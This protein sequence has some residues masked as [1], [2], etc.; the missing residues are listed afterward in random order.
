MASKPR[1]LQL[2]IIIVNYNVRDFLHHALISLRKATKGI[3]SE[4]I[5]VDN[6]SDDGSTE[7]LRKR[8]PNVT[9]IASKQNLGFARANN[10]ALKRARGAFLLLINPDTVVQ[11]DTLRAMLEFFKN[12]P[13]AGLAGC[14]ILNPDGTF[15][16]ACR[17]SF[18]TPWVAFTKI[19]GLSKLFPRSSWFGKYNLTYLSP[20]ETYEVDA[21][22]GSFMMLLKEVFE[23]VG[24]LDEEFFMYGEDLDW[25]YRIQQSGWKIYYAP[26][27]QIIHYKGESTRRSSLDEIQTFYDAMHRFVKKHFGRSSFLRIV[28]RAGIM[29]TLLGALVKSLLNPVRLAVVDFLLV[30]ISLVIAEYFRRGEVFMY[31]AYAYPIVYVVPATIVVASLY[32]AG[33]YTNRPMSISRSSVAVMAS[34]VVIA[35]LTALFT[36]YAFSR[37]IMGISGILS[38]FLIPGWRTMLKLFGR[39][40]TTERKGLLSKRTLIVGTGAAAIELCKKLRTKVGEGY[41]VIGFV[42]RT[43]RRVGEKIESVPILGSIENVGKVIREHRASDVIFSTKE[44]SYMSILSVLSRIRRQ[45]VNFHLVPNTL[46][47]MI[48]KA[49]VDTLDDLPLVQLSYNL[50]KPLHRIT[51]RLFDLGISALL[52]T[53]VYPIIRLKSALTNEQPSPPMRSLP[54]V[55]RGNMSFVGPPKDLMALRNGHTDPVNLGKPGITGLVQL[56]GERPMSPEEVDQYNLYYARNQS[57]LLD[58]EILI[59]TMLQRR[60]N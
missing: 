25:C 53:F 44:L 6:A 37:I 13:E 30:D 50:E 10:L 47:V 43:R 58:M 49:S 52:F 1:S 4:I 46:E 12:T 38:V 29:L 48:G 5:V 24:G 55:L 45:S 17:R 59:K 41:H 14:K 3:R 18:P 51:K 26:L 57:V 20:E 56:Q 15:Q 23:K 33:V 36:E 34:Y 7:M 39:V 42:D 22:S 9:L 60:K 2:S 28:L 19:F 35:S 21:V 8:F 54:A 32:I 40:Q 31:P 27:T 11:E 16:L